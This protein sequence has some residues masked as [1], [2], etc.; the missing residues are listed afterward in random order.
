M[1]KFTK[2]GKLGSTSINIFIYF[3]IFTLIN[4]VILFFVFTDD[5]IKNLSKDPRQRFVDL[6]YF[7]IMSITTVGYGD[8]T[9]KSKRAKIYLSL[10]VLIIFIGMFSIGHSFD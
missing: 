5:D 1:F 8:I 2:F 4:T 9:P 3:I 7:L 10:M 6:F